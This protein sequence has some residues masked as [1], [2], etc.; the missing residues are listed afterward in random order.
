MRFL[1]RRKKHLKSNEQETNN[2]KE[3]ENNT[4]KETHFTEDQGVPPEAI[5]TK[6]PKRID[7]VQDKNWI[8]KVIM[9]YQNQGGFDNLPGKGKPLSI[10]P[11]TDAFSGILKNAGAVPP[12]LALQHEIRS[13]I[14]RVISLM[15]SQQNFD[16]DTAI[17]DINVKIHKFNAQC[18]SSYLQKR[19]ISSH[20]IVKLYEEWK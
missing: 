16:L 14:Q 18:P 5:V 4:H 10:D 17:K 1:W 9:D 19:T 11:N 7:Y 13:D 8:D 6:Q 2:L 20:N 12:W 3:S 15:D